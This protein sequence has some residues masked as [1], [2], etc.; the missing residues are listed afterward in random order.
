M[1]FFLTY[2][3]HSQFPYFQEWNFFDKFAW[4]KNNEWL[5]GPTLCTYFGHRH[6]AWSIPFLPVSYYVPSFAL[7]VFLMFVPFFAMDHGSFSKNLGNYIAGS[8]LFVSGP[9]LADYFS[10]NK[11]ESASIWCF[12]SIMQVVGLVMLHCM[13]QMTRGNWYT[14]GK[15]SSS[16]G[17]KRVTRSSKKKAQ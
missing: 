4:V 2:V 14:K 1:R 12:F 8:L 7:H 3:E 15:E 16:S 10:V 17:G 11:H 5:N 9:V 13:N 6:L